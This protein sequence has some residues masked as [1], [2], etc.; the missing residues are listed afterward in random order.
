MHLPVRA[1]GPLGVVP[2]A[3]DWSPLQVLDQ[4]EQTR[5]IPNLNNYNKGNN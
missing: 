2:S 4:G 3:W 1:L 5:Q